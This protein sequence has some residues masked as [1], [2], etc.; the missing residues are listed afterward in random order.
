MDTRLLPFKYEDFVGNQELQTRKL[1]DYIGLPFDDACLH[2]QQ[3]KSYTPTPSYIQVQSEVTDTAVGRYKN[4]QQ[5]LSQ[6]EPQFADMLLDQG[7]WNIKAY[8][9]PYIKP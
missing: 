1:I 7:Y 8:S 5:Y 3:N 2:F 4:Y 9:A 6:Y